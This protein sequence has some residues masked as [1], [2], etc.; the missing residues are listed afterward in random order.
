MSG[1]PFGPG[2]SYPESPFHREYRDRWNTRMVIGT[3]LDP[4]EDLERLTVSR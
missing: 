3:P 1:Y 4:I 2:E